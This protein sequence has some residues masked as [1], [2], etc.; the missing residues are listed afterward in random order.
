MYAAHETRTP[1]IRAIGRALAFATCAALAPGVAAA[2][3]LAA[4]AAQEPGDDPAI[5]DGGVDGGGDGA[6]RRAAHAGGAGPQG[7]LDLRAA[8]LSFSLEP[9]RR[10]AVFFDMH[11]WRDGLV[12]SFGLTEPG[13]GLDPHP[14][15]EAT[16]DDENEELSADNRQQAPLPA[17]LPLL[18]VGLTLL[19]LAAR[20]WRR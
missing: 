10:P 14:D 7:L 1:P 2:L 8:P 16:V 9:E 3:P 12:E 6:Q 13:F 17:A 19:A 11:D 15:A 20:R 18:G 4:A 5:V